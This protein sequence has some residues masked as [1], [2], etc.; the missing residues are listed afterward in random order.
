MMAATL[1]QLATERLSELRAERNGGY[2]MGPNCD[3]PGVTLGQGEYQRRP[4]GDVENWI[5][6]IILLGVAAAIM[7]YLLFH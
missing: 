5:D 3:K 7:A 6:W 2:C 4:T 1:A